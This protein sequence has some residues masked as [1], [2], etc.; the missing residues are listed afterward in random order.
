MRFGGGSWDYHSGRRWART[1]DADHDQVTGHAD[2]LEPLDE[3]LARLLVL[4]T[5]ME[6]VERFVLVPRGQS[7]VRPEV[8]SNQE[9]V[10]PVDELAEIPPS[11]A[12]DRIGH[13][14]VVEAQPR[15]ERALRAG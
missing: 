1:L 11:R 10:V 2:P 7:D 12:N 8:H 5:V 4:H 15:G 14:E 9:V 13:V 6:A 3:P